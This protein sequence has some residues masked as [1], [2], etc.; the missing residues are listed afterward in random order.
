MNPAPPTEQSVAPHVVVAAEGT[1]LEQLH[2]SYA[3]LKAASDE[4]AKRLKSVTDAIKAELAA[5][6]PGQERVE[7]RGQSG[8][9]LRMTYVESWRLDS[10]R[11]KA[12]HLDVWVRYAVKGGSWQ[13]RPVSGTED[14]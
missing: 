11:L 13:L 8:P 3:D 1:R 7:L 10:K 5:A 2:A 4:A 9:P 14:E 12:E 6:E